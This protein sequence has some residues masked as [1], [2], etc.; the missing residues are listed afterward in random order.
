[1]PDKPLSELPKDHDKPHAEK[2]AKVKAEKPADKIGSPA[3]DS[4]AGKLI[5]ENAGEGGREGT[6]HHPSH[7]TGAPQVAEKAY[8]QAKPQPGKPKIG[9]FVTYRESDYEVS[10]E[11]GGTNPEGTNGTREH[12]ALVTRVWSPECVNLQ[13]FFDG[14]HVMPRVSV[15]KEGE[16]PDNTPEGVQRLGGNACWF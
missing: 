4:E 5:L 8:A 2:Q 3:K 10:A 6:G 15:M 14:N 16:S 11:G 7:V 1:M 9:S 13:V 12:P